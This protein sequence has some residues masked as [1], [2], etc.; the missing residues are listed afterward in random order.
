[1]VLEFEAESKARAEQKATQQGMSV[2]HVEDITDG[3]VAH[4][5]EPRH[6]TVRRGKMPLI[7]RLV[8][9]VVILALIWYF[10]GPMLRGMFGR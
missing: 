2:N 9:L 5:T 8:L 1:M 10:F 4:T 7:L 6:R 3:H